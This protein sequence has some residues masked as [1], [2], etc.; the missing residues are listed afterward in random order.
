MKLV[1]PEIDIKGNTGFSREIDIFKRS[2]FGERL[3]NTNRTPTLI[4][5][6]IFNESFGHLSRRQYKGIH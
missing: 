3:E 2:G 5:W 6:Y 1:L 4:Y